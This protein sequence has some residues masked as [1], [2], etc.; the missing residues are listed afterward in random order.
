MINAL[1]LAAAPHPA[2]PGHP[3]P[4]MTALATRLVATGQV[5]ITVVSYNPAIAQDEETVK[6]GVRY[7]YLKV[8]DDK[9]DLLTGYRRRVRRVR[10]YVNEIGSQYD[11]VH[12][13][14]T[15]Q[16]YA[17]MGSGLTM[18][19]VL[20]AQ[21]FV[22]EYY[23]YLPS[24]PEYRHAS[25][26]VASYY[27]KKY[28]PTIRHFIGR[29][30]WDKAIIRQLQPDAIIHHNWELMRPEFYE[31]IDATANAHADAMLF[32]GGLNDIKGIREALKALNMLRQKLP[33]RLIV[34]GYGDT[35]SLVK[36]AQSLNLPNVPASA[37]EHR[38][39]LSAP[40]LWQ[41]YHEAF[42]LLHPSY[43]DNSPNS[44]SEAQ[45]AGLPVVASN[46]G[47]VSSMIES[48]ETGILTSLEP[49]DIARGVEQ[50]WE[51]PDLRQKIARQA[52]H[53]SLERFDAKHITDETKAIYER[54]L[55]NP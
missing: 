52:R 38:G 20:S 4:W 40:Q 36:L 5:R 29:T 15:E 23:K 10:E 46:V 33:I 50:L 8:P 54:V 39:M 44:V 11:L 26:A 16:Q 45:L 18:P 19:K 13:H 55:S 32:V 12:I 17:A 48:G 7:I 35:E 31:P 2:K 25:W 41:A 49:V 30:H 37:L 6:D 1:W 24:K 27:E 43:I 3:T 47:G 34:T 28:A 21:G 9:I 14:G 53:I 42:C 51:S 22:T